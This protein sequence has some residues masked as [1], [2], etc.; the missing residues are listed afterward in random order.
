M[1]RLRKAP[2]AALIA[3]GLTALGL[4]GCGADDTATAAP[5][6]SSSTEAA[7]PTPRS[8]HVPSVASTHLSLETFD[9][10]AS[11]DGCYS[12]QNTSQDLVM[13]DLCVEGFENVLDSP[14]SMI[15]SDPHADGNM[16]AFV[17]G[18]GFQ[19]ATLSI[20][21][22]RFATDGTWLLALTRDG[23][24]QTVDLT[25]GDHVVRCTIDGPLNCFLVS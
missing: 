22:S 17:V 7:P 2:T 9:L 19:L 24:G 21:D 1:K 8:T 16:V 18:D 20:D 5:S 14:I 6:S 11:T 10:Y 4:I 15:A 3:L 12:L 23:E 25:D 13:G